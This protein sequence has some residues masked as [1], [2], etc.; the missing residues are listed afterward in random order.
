MYKKKLYMWTF[1]SV[2]LL[3]HASLFN[4][5]SPEV[6][7]SWDQKN[8]ILSF[9]NSG[10]EIQ[11]QA[12]LGNVHLRSELNPNF[13]ARYTYGNKEIVK[14]L[15]NVHLNI[16]SLGNKVVEIKNIIQEKKPHIF[17]V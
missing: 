4:K 2:V 15:K 5:T 8:E 13:W 7:G 17:G 10:Q 12:Y 9:K 16:R 6:L 11:K 14:G 1:I 3:F